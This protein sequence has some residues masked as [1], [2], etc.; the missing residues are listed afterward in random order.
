MPK[1]TL[2]EFLSVLSE[3]RELPEPVRDCPVVL[4]PTG[5]QLAEFAV[6]RAQ[7]I[8][9]R[10]PISEREHEVPRLVFEDE[11]RRRRSMVTRSDGRSE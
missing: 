10:T 1:A 8:P 6:G 11:C 3:A 4:G 9:N 5:G 2:E 7:A